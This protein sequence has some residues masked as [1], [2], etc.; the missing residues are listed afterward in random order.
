MF[1][2]CKLI[3]GKKATCFTNIGKQNMGRIYLNPL[4]KGANMSII[5]FNK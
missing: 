3:K 2:Q 1:F 5:N 4:F